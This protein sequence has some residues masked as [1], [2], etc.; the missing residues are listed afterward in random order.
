MSD[1]EYFKVLST[2]EQELAVFL[3]DVIGLPSAN[4]D[5]VQQ[6]AAV[7]VNH[8]TLIMGDKEQCDLWHI[9]TEDGF[10]GFVTG[11]YSLLVTLHG[12]GVAHL[13]GE[14]WY[15]TRNRYTK[16]RRLIS[17]QHEYAADQGTPDYVPSSLRGWEQIARFTKEKS[18]SFTTYRIIEQLL[19]EE[20]C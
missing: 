2:P 14:H 7:A 15:V 10:R 5:V 20:S 12:I 3:T 6:G 4:V 1:N 8:T 19:K 9:V 13:W 18:L 11:T 16:A 17:A